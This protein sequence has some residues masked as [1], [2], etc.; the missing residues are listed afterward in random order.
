M[1]PIQ[2]LAEGVP[3]EDV[4]A[5]L[6]KVT[7]AG[8]AATAAPRDLLDTIRRLAETHPEAKD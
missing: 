4:H 3:I 5:G 7:E 2:R 8:A 1:N 6:M